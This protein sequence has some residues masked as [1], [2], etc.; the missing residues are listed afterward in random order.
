MLHANTPSP[1]MFWRKHDW[2]D[3][4]IWSCA[5]SPWYSL[6]KARLKSKPDC[7]IQFNCGGRHTYASCETASNIGELHPPKS[8]KNAS[9]FRWTMADYICS[10]SHFVVRLQ[11]GSYIYIYIYYTLF[12]WLHI[13]IYMYVY[14]CVYIYI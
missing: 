4:T 6:K 7:V 1:D 10:S 2:N 9:F 3:G 5:T 8:I 11:S 12:S 14:V 13:Y